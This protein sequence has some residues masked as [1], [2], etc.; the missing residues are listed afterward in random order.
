MQIAWGEFRWEEA[1]QHAGRTGNR[2][3]RLIHP[4]C[5]LVQVSHQTIQKAQCQLKQIRT[6]MKS[7]FKMQAEENIEECINH[8][9]LILSLNMHVMKTQPWVEF[10]MKSVLKASGYP[11]I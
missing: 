6:L 10:V 4:N 3:N 7:F 5:L 8:Q 9:V 11:V 2:A 1:R